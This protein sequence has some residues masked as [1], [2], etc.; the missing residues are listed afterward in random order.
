MNDKI[1]NS[2]ISR[3]DFLYYILITAGITVVGGGVYHLQQRKML[4]RPLTTDS[5]LEQM[6]EA[7]ASLEKIGE[8]YLEK[9][10]M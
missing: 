8:K 3:K 6:S 2:E 7:E 1:K 5:L 10:P 9:Y 4:N